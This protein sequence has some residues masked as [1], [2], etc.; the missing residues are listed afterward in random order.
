[1]CMCGHTHH[2][3]SQPHVNTLMTYLLLSHIT[4]LFCTDI[5]HSNRTSVGPGGG[6][7]CILLTG[8]LDIDIGV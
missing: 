1:M 2:Y 4:G 3:L 7:I 6:F 5:D 8:E